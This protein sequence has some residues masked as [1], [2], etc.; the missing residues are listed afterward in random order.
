MIDNQTRERKMKMGIITMLRRQGAPKQGIEEQ[1]EG[2]PM[3]SEEETEA[4]PPEE[5]AALLKKKKLR[6]A[7]V[8]Y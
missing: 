5:E 6:A 7:P 2:S 4:S 1:L 8:S 3:P